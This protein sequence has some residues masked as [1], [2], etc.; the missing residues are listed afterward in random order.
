MV[1]SRNKSR[2][3]HGDLVIVISTDYRDLRKAAYQ[4]CVIATDFNVCRLPPNI[5]AESGSALG[6]AFVAAALC[7]GICVGLDFSN[8]AD[9]PNLLTILKGL[10][11]Q[12]LP[13]D[14]RSE[15]LNGINRPAEQ[16]ARA[17]EWLAI[18]GGSSTSALMMNQIAK[19]LGLRTISILDYRKHA[20]NNMSLDQK[21]IRPDIIVDNHDPQRA[22]EIVK[23]V[24]GNGL[25][26][27]VDT[28]GR[29]TAT[30]LMQCLRQQPPD[31]KE[32][33]PALTDSTI[34]STP[35][36]PPTHL[37]GLTGLPKIQPSSSPSTSNI[38]FHTVPIKLFHEVPEIGEAL[39]L[40]LERLLSQSLLTP[41]RILG[42]KE[43]FGAVNGAL[44]EMRRG[45]I[46]GGRVVVRV[47]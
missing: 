39:M 7:L 30:H 14:V 32:G 16:Q 35:V 21:F 24:T 22:I 40:W 41:P 28:V 3:R 8:V 15:C 33:N 37:V 43:G 17:G 11:P 36:L 19:L 23:S 26:F 12:R 10:D 13:E 42:V 45:D 47:V 38:T 34:S 4:E 20:L 2:F 31:P 5:P 27:A 6:V 1:P 44:D 46:S 25:R 9:G 29:E 18:W